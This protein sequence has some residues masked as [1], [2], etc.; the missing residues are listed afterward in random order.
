MRSVGLVR[1][2]LARLRVPERRLDGFELRLA[3]ARLREPLRPFD[4]RAGA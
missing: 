3:L 4:L 2:A 1:L